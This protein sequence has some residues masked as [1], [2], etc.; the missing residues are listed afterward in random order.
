MPS[1]PFF[2]ISLEDPISML[3]INLFSLRR[4]VLKSTKNESLVFFIYLKW[5]SSQNDVFPFFLKDIQYPNLIYE[6]SGREYQLSQKV[7]NMKINLKCYI[8]GVLFFKKTKTKLDLVLKRM[9][10]NLKLTDNR[11]F[12]NYFDYLLLQL[13]QRQRNF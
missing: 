9:K 3:S 12:F 6:T 2:Q 5:R 10:S 13:W 7:V 1:R 11:F 8:V 4:I